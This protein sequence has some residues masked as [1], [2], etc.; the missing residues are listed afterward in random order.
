MYILSSRALTFARASFPVAD[1]Q[2]VELKVQ[3]LLITALLAGIKRSEKVEGA[4]DM[5]SKGYD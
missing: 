5:R 4:K 1:G 2:C 3:G